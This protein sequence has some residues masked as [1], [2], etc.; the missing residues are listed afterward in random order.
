MGCINQGFHRSI[1]FRLPYSLLPKRRTLVPKPTNP[2]NPV[3]RVNPQPY[4]PINPKTPKPLNPVN[5]TPP[6]TEQV[7]V[8][9]SE[10][11]EGSLHLEK[12]I[13]FRVWGLS[14]RILRFS[15]KELTF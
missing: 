8:Q 13:G 1:G 12:L 15:R 7:R 5:C 10:V 3:N 4:K 6:Q 11:Q 9:G 2:A 14:L